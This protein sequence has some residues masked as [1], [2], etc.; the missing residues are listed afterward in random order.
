MPHALG[1]L[2]IE[3]AAPQDPTHSMTH[4]MM[5]TSMTNQP[6]HC[7][8]AALM[9]CV[10]LL[11][12]SASGAEATRVAKV[13]PPSHSIAANAAS[14]ESAS[15]PVEVVERL[16]AALIDMMK[17][18]KDLDFAGRYAFIEPVIAESFDLEFMGSKSVGRHWTKLDP[19]KQAQWIDRFTKLTTSNYAGRFVEFDGEHFETIGQVPAQRSTQMVQT[20]LYVPSDQDVLLYYRLMETERGWRIIDILM[21]GTVSEL[22]LRRSEYSTLLKRDGYDKLTRAIDEKI[23]ELSKGS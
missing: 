22:A 5:P 14:E 19:Q 23:E 13:A 2:P 16:H 4:S 8:R 10:A 6:T 12:A 17:R 1:G 15:E 18:S 21:K 20:K 9:A 11:W 7:A 3:A